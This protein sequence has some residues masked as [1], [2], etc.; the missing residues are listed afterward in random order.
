MYHDAATTVKIL[1]IPTNGVEEKVSSTFK[2]PFN[3]LEIRP[4]RGTDPKKRDRKE[5]SK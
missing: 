1:S 2:P 3:T 4:T 5:L